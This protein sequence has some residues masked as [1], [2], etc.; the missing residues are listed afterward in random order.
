MEIKLIKEDPHYPFILID[1]WYTDE[2]LPSVWKELE[3]YTNLKKIDRAE[4]RS[5]GA[6]QNGESLIKAKRFYPDNMYTKEYRESSPIIH[7]MKKQR[8]CKELHDVV[9]QCAPYGRHYLLSNA[10][11]TI[12]TYYEQKDEYKE[13]VDVFAW[14]F[15]VWLYKEPKAFNGGDFV[16]TDINTSI[17]VKNNRAVLFPSC[18]MHKVT[19]IDFISTNTDSGMGR[20]TISHF[21][22]NTT[23]GNPK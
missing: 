20:Y 19:P 6:K 4:D 7:Y 10:D 1:N 18:Y 3:Y 12:I 13:H 11:N 2:E 23:L 9:E 22:Y 8:E 21:Y 17:T 5:D 14:T 15:C 16:L